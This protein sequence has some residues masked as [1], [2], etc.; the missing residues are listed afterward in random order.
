MRHDQIS[1]Q[2]LQTSAY[3]A[4]G[5]RTK[6]KPF[7]VHST[8]V[9][10]SYNKRS[11]DLHKLGNNLAASIAELPISKKITFKLNINLLIS[12]NWTL[13]EK[14]CFAGRNNRIQVN[15]STKYNCFLKGP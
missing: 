3:F 7:A 14:P 5:K 2:T 6:R 10:R 11:S 12:E 13:K 9:S 1:T 4:R 15:K 8:A